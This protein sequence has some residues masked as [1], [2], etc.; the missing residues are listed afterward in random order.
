MVKGLTYSLDFFLG[1]LDTVSDVIKDNDDFQYNDFSPKMLPSPQYSPLLLHA[2]TQLY[3]T[4][5]Y[6]SPGDYHRLHSGD[7]RERFY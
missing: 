4:T 7:I 6:L 5:V 1:G 2:Q 3:E